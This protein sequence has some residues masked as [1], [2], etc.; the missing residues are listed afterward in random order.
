MQRLNLTQYRYIAG[1]DCPV[2]SDL[3]AFEE[4]LAFCIQDPTQDLLESQ[5]HTCEDVIRGT[6]EMIS[7]QLAS[8]S[9]V[10]SRIEATMDAIR[11]QSRDKEDL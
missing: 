2:C 6:K 5:I 7:Q 10:I 8:Y 11:Q 9:R 1:G 3:P 4:K